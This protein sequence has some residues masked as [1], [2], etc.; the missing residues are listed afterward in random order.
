VSVCVFGYRGHFARVGEK[1]QGCRWQAVCLRD[2]LIGLC[3]ARGPPASTL[4]C[5]AAGVGLCVNTRRPTHASGTACLPCIMCAGTCSKQGLSHSQRVLSCRC[6]AGAVICSRRLHT[7]CWGRRSKQLTGRF[8]CTCSS[9]ASVCTVHTWYPSA[10]APCCQVQQ[11]PCTPA[12]V[13]V[14]SSRLQSGVGKWVGQHGSGVRVCFGC[15]V[16]QHGSGVRVCF[17]CGVA[18]GMHI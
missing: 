18:A 12:L 11:Q 5:C 2:R 9:E 15:G 6:C 14:R 17:G 3:H 4:C 1:R 16:G 8:F 10:A 13:P 7:I